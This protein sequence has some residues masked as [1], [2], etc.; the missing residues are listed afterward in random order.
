MGDI[1]GELESRMKMRNTAPQ[2]LDIFE[3]IQTKKNQ[4][5]D[6]ESAE[7]GLSSH[8]IEG[9]NSQLIF[10][11]S[12]D[13]YNS[14]PVTNA[15]N[16]AE[17]TIYEADPSHMA[18]EQELDSLQSLHQGNQETIASVTINS[19][20]ECMDRIKQIIEDKAQNEMELKKINSQTS[21]NGIQLQNID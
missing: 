13:A 10:T 11:D 9:S 19:E 3:L 8:N 5:I 17:G 2:R 12:K 14:T 1:P 7:N 20:N 15:I 6:E 21:F 16:L 4:V 18:H